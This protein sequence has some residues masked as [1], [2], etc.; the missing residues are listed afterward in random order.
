[1][2]ISMTVKK[3]KFPEIAAAMQRETAKIVETSAR[4]ISAVVVARIMEGGKTGRIYPR[5]GGG[6]HQASA[7]G[8]YP[9]TDY[10]ALANSYASGV[11]PLNSQK[12]KWLVYTDKDY[13]APLEYGHPTKSGSFVAARPHLTPVAEEERP[14]FV[15]AMRNLERHI[16]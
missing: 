13:A 9:A 16:R 3:N 5:P 6:T 10:G 8:E 2:K 4:R 15:A 11:E 12:T 7:P 1:M 14:R